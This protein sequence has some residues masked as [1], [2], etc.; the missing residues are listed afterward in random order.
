MGPV[1]LN[2]EDPFQVFS[3]KQSPGT[4]TFHPQKHKESAKSLK[5][6]KNLTSRRSDI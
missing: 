3:P 5:I 6:L 4:S 2:H 1:F